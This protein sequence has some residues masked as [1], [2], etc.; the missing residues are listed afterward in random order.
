MTPPVPKKYSQLT[1][2]ERSI[3]ASMNNHGSSKSAI[4]E[5]LGRSP[6][7]ISRE[8]ER[9]TVL[10]VYVS[11]KADMKCYQR[12]YWVTKPPAK[13]WQMKYLPLWKY[14]CKRLTQKYPWSPEE[15]IHRWKLLYPWEFCV[16]VPTFY[17][18][19]YKRRPDLCQRLLSWHERRK[20]RMK[21]RTTKEMIPNRVWIDK[22]PEEIGTKKIAW[23][24]EWDTLWSK[25]WETD[26]L[27]GLREKRSR[28]L[29][30]KHIPS[31]CKTNTTKCFQQWRKRHDIRSATLDS[32][33]EFRDH[34]NYGCATYFCHPYSS[35]EK[36]QIE[37]GM[38]MLRKKYPKKSSLHLR[39]Q[40]A[41]KELQ[42]FVKALNDTPMKCLWW[43][44]PKEVL[45]NLEPPIQLP[46]KCE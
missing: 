1:R 9:N 14:A 41:K 45:Y 23:H 43:K 28:Y 4:A 12:R 26:T 29:L 16:S 8:L 46:E 30:A 22:R 33:L 10:G 36:W 34:E 19:L 21:H 13:L 44:T 6:S 24:W 32:W 40:K 27:V 37:N 25:K 42:Q 20:K 38:R 18:Y 3:I 39:T 35:W 7:T 15:I 2:E 31:R 17:T 5:E 11:K